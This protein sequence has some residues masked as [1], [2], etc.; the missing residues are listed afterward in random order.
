ME[1]K[2]FINN[3]RRCKN[4][5]TRQIGTRIFN[6]INTTLLTILA[7][8]MILPFIHVLGSSFATGAEIARRSSSYFLRVHI[9]RL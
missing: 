5:W 4:D 6:I 7:L 2:E 8:I 1:K 3:F 9:K